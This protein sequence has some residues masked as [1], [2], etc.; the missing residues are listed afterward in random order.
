MNATRRGATRW[1]ADF[2]AALAQP[3]RGEAPEASLGPACR[4]TTYRVTRAM[5]GA[6][7]GALARWHGGDDGRSD[8]RSV[9]PDAADAWG[10]WLVGWSWGVGEHYMNEGT[11]EDMDAGATG[12]GRWR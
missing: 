9:L 4:V 5:H 8:D 6:C 3:R 12:D 2:A 7:G 1:R 10:G 11:C